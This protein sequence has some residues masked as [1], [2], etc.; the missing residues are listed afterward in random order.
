VEQLRAWQKQFTDPKEFIDSLKIDFLKDRIFAIS[1]KGKVIDLPQ[2]ATPVDFA[3]HIHSDIGNQCIGAKVNGKIVS[4]DYELTSGDI[5]EILTQKNKKPSPSWLEFVKTAT[6]KGHIREALRKSG[7]QGRILSEKKKR[8][9]EFKITAAHQ[10]GLMKKISSIL[11]RSHVNVLGIDS[12]ASRQRGHFYLI[13]I[14]C[15]CD[16]KDRVLKIILKLKSLKEIKEIDYR[17]V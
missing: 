9:V 1:P 2:G 17:F 11:A 13:K 3:F 8:Q 6:A 10:F 4:L 15:D 12:T 5:V 14:R 16:D 7:L